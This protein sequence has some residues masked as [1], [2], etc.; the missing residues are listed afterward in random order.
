MPLIDLN[1]GRLGNPIADGLNQI[2][3]ARERQKQM[4]MERAKMMMQQAN[5]D[6]DNQRANSF[7][8]LQQDQFARTGK[9]EDEAKQR[10][11]AE[12]YQKIYQAA[13]H[14]PDMARQLAKA[15]GYEI[16]ET[17][18]GP[19][20]VQTSQ[21][22]AKAPQMPP[23]G[24]LMTPAGMSS[25]NGIPQAGD[26]PGVPPISPAGPGT[27]Q[28]APADVLSQPLPPS[29]P[30]QPP[31]F[32][33]GGQ[34]P[35]PVVSPPPPQPTE[36]Q[37]TAQAPK[38]N[39]I[40]AAFRMRKAGQE[41]SVDPSAARAEEE[42]SF[43]DQLRLRQA[44]PDARAAAAAEAANKAREFKKE[45][46]E[47]YK[48]NVGMQDKWHTAMARAVALKGMGDSGH[49]GVIATLG[50]MAQQGADQAALVQVAAAGGLR[51]PVGIAMKLRRDPEKQAELEVRD[52]AGNVKGTASS[53]RA[54]K[55]AGDS[56]A[57]SAA[58]QDAL[59]AF[60]DHIVQHGNLINPFSDDYK[61]RERLHA[62]VLSKGRVAA[63]LGV[64]N[65]NIELEHQITG[66]S[67]AGIN[68]MA[69]PESIDNLIKE[70]GDIADKRV[71]TIL[72]PG[73]AVGPDRRPS[74]MPT[75]KPNPI[76]RAKKTQNLNGEDKSAVDWANAH[77]NDPRSAAILKA[78]GL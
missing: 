43:A 44:A 18:S 76:V 26:V 40:L 49:A 54:A 75:K 21:P 14:D 42:R 59:R 46:D 70:V 66:G 69:S 73:A 41:F 61:E 3:A 37:V 20:A 53:T 10:Q 12:D 19:K 35:T 23:D 17:P 60:K 22:A 63:Q 28:P 15:Y 39:P 7:L 67:G 64:S 27:P 13:G 38:L 58:Y 8:K 65:K 47:K 1:L 25:D 78:N 45:E 77:P 56:L 34:A 33:Q 36:A 4:D 74:P 55:Q 32:V 5:Q 51:D 11:G 29:G 31:P 71:A 6:A 72:R 50:E 24:G 52:A 68:R 48:A 16:V 62:D 9:N 57:A 30:T 2:Q